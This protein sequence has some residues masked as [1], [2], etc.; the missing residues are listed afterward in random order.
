MIGSISR[1]LTISYSDND[2]TKK[3]KRHND[4]LHI[5]VDTKGKRIPM[6]LIDDRNA[7]N[8]CPL[9]TASC[10]GLSI[11]DFVPFDQHVRAYDNSRRKVLGTMTLELTIGLMIKKVEFQM[12]NITSCFNMPLELPWIHDTKV[13]PS[14]L[15]Q[16]VQFPHE[17]AIVTIYGNTLTIPKPIFGINFENEPLTLDGF[18]IE[19][20]GFE[21][22]EEEIEMIPMDFDPYSNNNVVAM[23]RNMS[24]FPGMNL[25][26]T[27]K[28][29]TTQ[30]PIIPTVTPPFGLGYKPTDDDLL[31]M[32]V[33]RM[34]R[35]KAK[36][37]GLPCPSKPLKPY[38]PTLNGKFVKAGDSQ[39]Y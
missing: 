2:L 5:I 3:G 38:T 13:V 32:E 26:M 28:E 1:E 21:K 17:G 24:Y 11:E 25:R 18:K 8:V 27:V 9:K 23:M 15:C 36:A 16:K 37:K 12:L 6:V 35:A 31:N 34:T 20:P 7:L 29:A 33:R 19:K 39:R 30:V 22:R 10:L 14:S 4:P